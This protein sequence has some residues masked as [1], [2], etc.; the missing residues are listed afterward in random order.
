MPFLPAPEHGARVVVTERHP[1]AHVMMLTPCGVD[2]W[3]R[4]RGPNEKG[5]R[6]RQP[7]KRALAPLPGAGGA[8]SGELARRAPVQQTRCPAP[9]PPVYRERL[10]H[11][12]LS[13]YG[14]KSIGGRGFP[15]A[16]TLPKKRRR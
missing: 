11:L 4:T 16:P 7:S 14:R 10:P 3:H 5:V 12:Y 1:R 9:E 2:V 8:A 6:P 13:K 15:A